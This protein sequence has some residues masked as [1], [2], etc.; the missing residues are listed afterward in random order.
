MCVCKLIIVF[1]YA[2]VYT[3]HCVYIEGWCQRTTSGNLFSS[4]MCVLGVKLWLLDLVANA[5]TNGSILLAQ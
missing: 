2:F 4:L 5:F 1:I 3:N